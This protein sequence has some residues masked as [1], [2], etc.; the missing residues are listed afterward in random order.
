MTL[1]EFNDVMVK[2]HLTYTLA[3]AMYLDSA[4]DYAKKAKLLDGKNQVA[5]DQCKQRQIEF[6]QFALEQALFESHPSGQR[7]EDLADHFTQGELRS[8]NQ[9]IKR[10]NKVLAQFGQ[11]ISPIEI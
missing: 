8:S 2:L 3:V 11:M 5:A 6:E 1:T 9:I 4:A 7:F 10:W